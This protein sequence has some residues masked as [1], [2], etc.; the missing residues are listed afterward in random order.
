MLGKKMP[1]RK[2]LSTI[3][4]RSTSLSSQV[5]ITVKIVKD[6]GKPL[7]HFSVNIF[8]GP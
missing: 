3:D 5:L 6:L 2:S 8:K 1:T 4:L 7:A